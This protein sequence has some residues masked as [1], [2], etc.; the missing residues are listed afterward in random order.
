MSLRWTIDARDR[1]VTTVAEGAVT[2]H[3][4]EKLVAAVDEAGAH[5]Y[6]KLFD[7]SRADSSMSAEDMLAVGGMFR[8]FHARAS[9]GALA[10]VLPASSAENFGRLLGTLAAADRPL[11]IFEKIAPARRWIREQGKQQADMA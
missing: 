2:R 9:M 10:L 7:G 8:S 1:L 5:D 4:I 3:D 6:R 11:R